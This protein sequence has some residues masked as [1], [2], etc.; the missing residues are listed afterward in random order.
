MSW[1]LGCIGNPPNHIKDTLQKT[2]N[3]P[4]FRKQSKHLSLFAGGNAQTVFYSDIHKSSGW[5]VCGL[6]LDA[7]RHK[8]YTQHDW[9][10]YILQS[11]PDEFIDGHYI[12]LQWDKKTMTCKTDPLGLRDMYILPEKHYTL[13]STRTDYLGQITP[14]ELDPQ[15]FGSKWLSVTS[16]TRKSIFRNCHR[17]CAGETAQFTSDTLHIQ[18]HDWMPSLPVEHKP[19]EDFIL[20]IASQFQQ[21]I[22]LPLYTDRKLKV[23]F[24]A[25]FDSRLLLACLIKSRSPDWH[26]SSFG[27]DALPDNISSRKITE[28]LDIEHIR[29]NDPL[30]SAAEAWKIMQNYAARSLLTDS[31]SAILQLRYFNDIRD[32]DTISIDGW[33]GEFWRREFFNKLLYFG[34]KAILSGNADY[35]S[36]LLRMNRA[37][38]F[39]A[40]IQN[41]L[42]QGEQQATRSLMEHLPPPD[43]LGLVNWLA[44]FAIRTKLPNAMGPEQA[45]I[46]SLCHN[47]MPLSQYS[48]LQNLFNIPVNYRKNGRLFKDIIQSISPELTRFPLIKNVT[49]KPFRM[50][51][52]QFRVWEKLHHQFGSPYVYEDKFRFLMQLKEPVMDTFFSREAQTVSWYDPDTIKNAIEAF[53]QGDKRYFNEVDWWI[54]FELFRQAHRI[55]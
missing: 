16:L 32:P 14:L 30:P 3:F 11:R 15:Q 27:P 20:K 37:A 49:P 9:G 5:I 34:K 24:S 42:E 46:D 40:K 8:I 17:L 51:S 55:Q 21:I 36:K 45:R 33:G 43:A 31:V 7:A 41:K 22:T 10:H 6:G 1:L 48:L 54:T 44:L 50:T 18:K 28:Q 38:I 4:F 29:Y 2:A 12:I 25:G 52:M 35:V 23:F 39:N 53:F 26:V 19:T 47:Y 13:F